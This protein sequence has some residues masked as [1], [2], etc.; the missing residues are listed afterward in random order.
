MFLSIT[1]LTAFDVVPRGGEK[2]GVNK[3]NPRSQSE[4]YSAPL[5]GAVDMRSEPRKAA[6]NT[7][8]SV[9]V[10][11]RIEYGCAVALAAAVS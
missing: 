11:T 10:M 6:G 4:G 2:Q 8:S 5:A 3:M 7:S 1:V 9:P